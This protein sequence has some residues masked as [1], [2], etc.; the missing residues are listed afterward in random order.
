[1]SI[2]TIGFGLLAAVGIFISRPANAQ[3]QHPY[4]RQ[5]VTD[6]RDAR[7]LLLQHI[8]GQPMTHNEKEALRM[9][10]QMIKE[11]S[12]VSPS[13]AKKYDYEDEPKA[14]KDDAARIKQCIDLLKKAKDDLGHEQDSQFSGLRDRSL[15][16]CDDAIRFVARSKRG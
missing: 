12:E 4:C 10:N 7:W 15:K 14:C 5:A 2:R 13:N 8:G 6:L 9:I 3:G 16:N 11:I 1:M